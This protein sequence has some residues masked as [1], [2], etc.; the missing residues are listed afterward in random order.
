MQ[1]GLKVQISSLKEKQPASLH[2]RVGIR[3]ANLSFTEVVEAASWTVERVGR[4]SSHKGTLVNRDHG[5]K[6][7]QSCGSC[8]AN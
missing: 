6:S 7:K 2:V 3:I 4:Y 5:R 1:A 8:E